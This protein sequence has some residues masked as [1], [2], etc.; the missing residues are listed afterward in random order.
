MDEFLLRNAA[1]INLIDIISHKGLN[2]ISSR[3]ILFEDIK[4][5]FKDEA[6]SGPWHI[7]GASQALQIDII[8]IHPTMD[9]RIKDYLNTEIR[10]VNSH[11]KFL[12]LRKIIF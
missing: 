4:D 11:G 6:W 2:F 3:E 8:P 9:K 10:S 12:S 1:N 7:F 5:S